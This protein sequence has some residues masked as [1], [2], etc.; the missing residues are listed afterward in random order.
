[1]NLLSL[2]SSWL[3]IIYQVT[4]K[5][6]TITFHHTFRKLNAALASILAEVLWPAKGYFGWNKEWIIILGS[7]FSGAGH[8]HS[9]VICRRQLAGRCIYLSCPPAGT[10]YIL[11][12]WN[13]ESTTWKVAL[14]RSEQSF[15][16]ESFFSLFFWFGGG[17]DAGKPADTFV[18][19]HCS[20]HGVPFLQR[21]R[22]SFVTPPVQVSLLV[23][24]LDVCVCVWWSKQL[25]T[26]S[27]TKCQWK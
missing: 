16:K 1:M 2:I 4:T 10:S 21:T 9:F 11:S 14:I 15:R 6:A 13:L 19:V 22:N 24:H 27:I 18:L 8:A 25:W 20:M 26:H 17:R 12:S 23:G 5:C 3:D 7:C